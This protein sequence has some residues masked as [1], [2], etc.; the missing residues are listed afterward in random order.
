MN[1]SDVY[2]ASLERLSLEAKRTFYRRSQRHRLNI[3]SGYVCLFVPWLLYLVIYSLT[4]FHAY[5]THPD[6]CI[7]FVAI[8]GIG[9]L[10]LGAYA[11]S[12][13]YRKASGSE[14]HEPNW[15]AFLFLTCSAAWVCGLIFGLLNFW[16]NMQPYYSFLDMEEYPEVNPATTHGR[17]VMDAGIV[18]WSNTTTLDLKHS[19]GFK[20]SDTYCVAPITM[21][22]LALDSY[23]FWAV[24]LGCCSSNANDFQCG[25]YRK[26]GSLQGLRMLRDEDRA[27]YRL[28]ITQAEA[29]YQIRAT[30][31]L[32]F[33]WVEDAHAEMYNFRNMGY[34]YCLIGMI[35]HLGWQMLCVALAMMSFS[36]RMV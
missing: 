13:L 33:Y 12:R 16:T 21:D 3:L 25:E 19:M 4:S 36:K 29:A 8:I 35:A 31:P 17:Q 1:E 28:A 11:L 24:G 27:F 7:F 22:N 10:W 9:I 32:L 20:N 5:Y 15:W 18:H 23:D 26:R 34:R 2:S 30:H 6:L 14:D